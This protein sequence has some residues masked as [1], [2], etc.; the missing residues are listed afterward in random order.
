MAT[1]IL[2]PPNL[3]IFL[4]VGKSHHPS[5]GVF[6]RNGNVTNVVTRQAWHGHKIT[7]TNALPIEGTVFGD[8]SHFRFHRMQRHCR[9]PDCAHP[10]PSLPRVSAIVGKVQGFLGGHNAAWNPRVQLKRCLP[11]PQFIGSRGLE[12][13]GNSGHASSSVVASVKQAIVG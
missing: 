12:I 7:R 13:I 1:C 4:I 10:I 6:S 9:A 8:Q 11:C 3:R 2:G 5:R